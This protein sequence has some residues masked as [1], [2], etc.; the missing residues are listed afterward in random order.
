MTMATTRV[1]SV[2]II[3]MRRGGLGGRCASR[4]Q[5]QDLF[6]GYEHVELQHELWS[7]LHE[8]LKE[9]ICIDCFFQCKRRILC[10]AMAC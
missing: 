8:A 6:G 7:A 2:T 10:S 9:L 5:A 3:T 4:V 1:V